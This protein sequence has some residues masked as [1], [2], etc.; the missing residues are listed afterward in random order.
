VSAGAATAGRGGAFSILD[1]PVCA[2]A[3]EK[4]KQDSQAISEQDIFL[5]A[6][7]IGVD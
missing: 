1:E 7:V 6:M 4:H 3:I 5:V 2:G